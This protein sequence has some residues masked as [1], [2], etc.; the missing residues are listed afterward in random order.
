MQAVTVHPRRLGLEGEEGTC[1]A[2]EGEEGEREGE[3]SV[4]GG[5]WEGFAE[6]GAFEFKFRELLFPLGG[7]VSVCA[8]AWRYE[9]CVSGHSG[10]CQ[11]E[12]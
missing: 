7:G 5:C 2:V 6:E 1:A 8:K 9:C 11:L 3:L 10:K 4:F 12:K